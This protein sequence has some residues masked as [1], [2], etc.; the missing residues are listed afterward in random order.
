MLE[1]V[2]AGALPDALTIISAWGDACNLA[3]KDDC[4]STR[5]RTQIDRRPR[6]AKR[7]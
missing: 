7:A 3:L 4:W 5:G 2:T 1:V 6:D